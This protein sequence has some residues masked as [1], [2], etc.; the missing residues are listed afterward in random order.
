MLLDTKDLWMWRKGKDEARGG[1]VSRRRG[2]GFGDLD[3]P[4]VEW[5]TGQYWRKAGQLVP[6]KQGRI[7]WA[8]M[9]FGAHTIGQLPALLLYSWSHRCS[10][11]LK[12]STS[13]PRLSVGLLDMKYISCRVTCS[14]MFQPLKPRS[15]PYIVLHPLGTS[16]DTL[17]ILRHSGVD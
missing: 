6:G 17:S 11:S 1:Q 10:S 4:A 2:V 15:S 7:K 3:L 5:F 9:Q 13:S 12:F 16:P 14:L 8:H